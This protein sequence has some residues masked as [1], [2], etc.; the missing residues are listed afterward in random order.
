MVHAKPALPAGHGEVLTRPAFDEWAALARANHDAAA[1]VGLHGRRRAGGGAARAG[2][3][4]GARRRRGVLG[5]AGRERGASRARRTAR[6]WRPDTSRSSTTRACGSR[7]SCSSDSPRSRSATALD[8]VVDS[9]GF[10]TLGVSSPCMTPGVRRCQ[11]YLAVGSAERVVRERAGTQRAR[12]ERL[13]RGRRQ[14]ARLAP[15]AGRPPP[16]RGLL[17]RPRGGRAARG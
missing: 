1:G 5:Q 11:Q 7:T 8:F 4:R 10:Q 14:H 6:S 3:P 13:L 12:P 16:L 2:P 17:R 9:D 15:G